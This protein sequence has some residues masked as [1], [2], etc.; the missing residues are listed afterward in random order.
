[1]VS[2]A[3]LDW[4]VR[5]IQGGRCA[6]VHLSYNAI[7]HTEKI[8]FTLEAACSADCLYRPC[9]MGALQ[10][11]QLAM[12]SSIVTDKG[13]TTSQQKSVVEFWVKHPFLNDDGPHCES[14]FAEHPED[15]DTSGTDARAQ[16]F[17]PNP[18]A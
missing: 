8:K 6:T 10:A 1:M 3:R 4:L 17:A 14:L 18:M 11:V 13:H 9:V 12:M 7:T 15:P 16:L 2:C 5:Q